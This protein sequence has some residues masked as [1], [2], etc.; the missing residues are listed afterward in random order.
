MSVHAIL[1]GGTITFQEGKEDEALKALQ[2]AAADGRWSWIRHDKLTRA[3]TIQ[4]G[5]RACRWEAAEKDLWFSGEKLGDEEQ[6]FQ[7]LAPWV[8]A[9]SYVEMQVQ[10]EIWTWHFD[11]Q[12]C[13]AEDKRYA[14]EHYA[15][16]ANALKD[17]PPGTRL[18]CA[19]PI[20]SLVW[21][22]TAGRY[23]VSDTDPFRALTRLSALVPPKA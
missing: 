14:S 4:E 1:L 5:L 20:E 16:L 15:A 7:V 17:A 18:T 9:G 3:T 23:V 8:Q 6:I 13:T 22:A 19:A 11:G 21:V 10:G 2:Q 12:K